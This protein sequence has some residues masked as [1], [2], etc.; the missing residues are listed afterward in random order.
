MGSIYSVHCEEPGHERSYSYAPPTSELR[1]QVSSTD[2][3]VRFARE[4]YEAEL[5]QLLTESR[6]RRCK[7]RRHRYRRSSALGS[8][9]KAGY[10][11]IYRCG[12][13]TLQ[14]VEEFIYCLY[15]DCGTPADESYL[16][17]VLDHQLVQDL[18]SK[19]VDPAGEAGE[20]HT[21]V[22]AGPVFHHTVE[23][24]FGPIVKRAGYS[25]L[26]CS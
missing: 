2:L 14:L 9:C 1:R 12:R 13:I 17:R 5:S 8:R 7:Y 3:C 10:G 18:L 25:F 23:V 15:R 26:T 20:F 11:G 22:T 4:T 16:G 6:R 19:K 21:V 24:T